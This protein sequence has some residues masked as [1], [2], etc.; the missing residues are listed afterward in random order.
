ER[1]NL[2]TD[3]FARDL[4][5]GF[6]PA[7]EFDR[8][9]PGLLMFRGWGLERQ[10]S[11][12]RRRYIDGLRTDIEK[13]RK[14]QPPKYAFVHGVT[15]SDKPQNLRVSQRGSPYNLGDE[16]PRHFLS[17]LS[18]GDPAAFAK[19]SGRLELADAILHQPIAARVIVNR[20]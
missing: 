5:E 4:G 19:G 10:L 1:L 11:A 16:A 14:D 17:I 3:V 6:D 20:I 12:D 9:K 7:Q 15:D 18:D 2:W 8:I 13:L